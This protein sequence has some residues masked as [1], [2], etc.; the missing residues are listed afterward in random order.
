MILLLACAAPNP[1]TDS[2]PAE[3]RSD[4][5]L[6]TTQPTTLVGSAEVHTNPDNPFS[7]FVTVTVNRPAAVSIEYSA[8]GR[9]QT[10][11]E[12][13]I[14]ADAPTN[15]LVLGLRADSAYTLRAVASTWSSDPI[16][17]QTDPLPE[18]FPTCTATFSVDEASFDPEEVTC[19]NSVLTTGEHVYWCADAWGTPVSSMRTTADDSLMSVTPMPGG[20]VSTSNTNSKIAFFDEAGKELGEYRVT[21]FNSRTDYTHDWID[22]H[23]AL[24]I[25][26]GAYA[27]DVVIITDATEW[28]ADGDHKLGNGIVVYDPVTYAVDYEY[29]FHGELGDEIEMDP[30]VPYTRPGTGDDAYDWTHLN[31]IDH[32]AD[33]DGREFFLLSLKAQDWVVKLYP[34]TNELAWVLGREGDFVLVDEAGTPLPDV[35]WFF[36]QHSVRIVSVDGERMRLLL[37]D[38]GAWRQ[39]ETGFRSD[40]EYSR[41]LELE[42]DE[43]SRQARMVWSYGAT[44]E[45]APDWMYSAICGSVTALPGGERVITNV[46]DKGERRELSYPDGA[47]RWRLRCD[48]IDVCEYR[49]RWY[50]SLYDLDW[51]SP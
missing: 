27:G 24:P 50:P 8:D 47:E 35:D 51:D 11:P 9:V 40:L 31:A 25:L 44:D 22:N 46:G 48:G 29:S 33:A 41:A 14:P 17:W 42:L 49:T 32:G 38:N 36:H 10:T 34:D 37:Y 18:G 12:Q 3:T 4:A 28:F 13:I 15:L 45:S 26:E 1:E 16:P 7:A 21:W 5:T 39:D 43:A 30:K 6:S 19:T 20:F 2:S 23:E